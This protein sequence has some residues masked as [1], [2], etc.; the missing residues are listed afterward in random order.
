MSFLA[1]TFGGSTRI[2]SFQLFTFMFG[3]RLFLPATYLVLPVNTF[4]ASS[5][6]TTLNPTI[7]PSSKKKVQTWET[8]SQVSFLSWLLPT[9]AF[10]NTSQGLHPIVPSRMLPPTR[11][12]PCKQY[13]P[14][15]PDPIRRRETHCRAFATASPHFPR[16]TQSFRRN[17]S[18][19]PA[20]YSWN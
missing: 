10:A 3:S 5:G 14:R 19:F 7:T 6:H 20:P 1:A 15:S 18:R 8:N 4:F 16:Q 11:A 9:C 17:A 13:L 2:P 12:L